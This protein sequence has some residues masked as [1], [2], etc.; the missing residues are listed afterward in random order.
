MCL[1]IKVE[2][3]FRLRY[4]LIQK[5]EQTSLDATDKRLDNIAKLLQ[6]HEYDLPEGTSPAY[7]QTPFPR[8]LKNGQTWG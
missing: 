4:R 3:R 8:V 6:G 7:S 2:F 5:P 1:N